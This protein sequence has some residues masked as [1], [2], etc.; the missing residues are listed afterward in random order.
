MK[1]MFKLFIFFLLPFLF[2]NCDKKGKEIILNPEEPIKTEEELLNQLQSDAFKY[3]WDYA[4]SN[5]KLARERYHVDEPEFD[6]HVVASGG[7][8]FGLLNIIVAIERGFISRT[9]AVE[10]LNTAL[11]FLKNADRF[12]GAWSHWIDGNTGNVIPFGTFDNGGDIVETA[13]LCQGLICVREYFKNGNSTEQAVAISADSLWKQVEWNWYTKGENALYWHWSPDYQWQLNFKIEGY[14]ECLITYILAASS[15]TFPIA[16]EAYHQAWAR[17]GN[18]VSDKTSYGLPI[19]LN[20]NG[21]STVGPL[22]WSHY[23]FL[24]L[25]PNGLSDTYADYFELVQ[26]HT[27]VIYNYCVANPLG[28]NGYCNECWGLTASYTRNADG[29][30]GYSAHQPNNDRGVITPTAALSSYPFTP[31]QSL[32]FLRYLYEKNTSQYIGIMGPYDAF[33][34]HHHWV[35]KRYLS[36]DQGTISPM[37]ENYRTG[38][39]WDLFMNAPEIRQGLLKLGFHSTH[40]GF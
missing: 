36:I 28:W 14:N 4:E 10:R 16:P 17:N 20:H 29:T 33:S 25:N 8:G 23:S 34:F 2:D 24:A 6:A 38:L 18:I 11:E 30:V 21:T 31:S 27:E 35:T 1:P 40:Y 5:S 32:A 3:F 7:S 15:P 37:I 13:Y 9:Q 39:L 12:H 26:N 22:F 19:V